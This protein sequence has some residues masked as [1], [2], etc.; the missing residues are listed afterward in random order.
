MNRY[1]ILITDQA[2]RCVLRDFKSDT[3][4][5]SKIYSLLQLHGQRQSRC[6]SL[7]QKLKTHLCT[8]KV[9]IFF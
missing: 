5:D 7:S 1:M 8:N 3:I 9:G 4:N 6:W 2:A